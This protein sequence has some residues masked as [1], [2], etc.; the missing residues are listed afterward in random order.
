MRLKIKKMVAGILLFGITLS[1]PV[2][3]L[4]SFADSPN[5][6]KTEDWMKT[7]PDEMPLSTVTIPGTHDSASEYIFPGYFLN[8]QNTSIRQ[9]L[10]NGYRYLDIRVAVTTD[11][12][13]K[14]CLKFVHNFGTCRKGFSW[15]SGTLYVSETIRD[16]TAYLKKH[17]SETVIFCVNAENKKDNV[18]TVQKLLYKMIEKDKSAWYLKNAIPTMKECRGKIVLASRFGNPNDYDTSEQ[19]L[20]F[21]WEDQGGKNAVDIPYEISMINQTQAL[22]VQ[23]RYHYNIEMKKDAFKEDIENCQAAEDTFSLNFLSTAG[24][25]KMGHP[26][27]LAQVLNQ[28]FMKLKL[29]KG[30]SYGI[31]IVDFA[32]RKLAR[33][34]I[35]ANR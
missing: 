4:P 19:G 24:S 3:A 26:K 8:C 16:I 30:T 32:N 10:E 28:Q 13:G 14:Q 9:Q 21:A 15:F 5:D 35:A 25:G 34:I 20:N 22:W 7:I 17:P 23:D 12:H 27:Q 18:K 1:L 6:S 29:H 2:S 33:K 11:K 31:L